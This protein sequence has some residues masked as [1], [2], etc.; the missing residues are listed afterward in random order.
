MTTA[1][2]LALARKKILE[3]S[4]EIV[5][6]ATLLIYGN[7][8]QDDIAKKAF[9]NSSI[10][11]ATVNFTN[12]T[13]TNLPAN[14]GTLYGDA[15]EN[16]YN[17]FPEMSPQDFTRD[18]AQGVTVEGGVLKVYPA[19]T[20]QLE[21]KY[22]PTFTSITAEVDPSIDTYLHEPIVYGIVYRALEDLQEEARAKYYENKYNEMINEKLAVL[23]NYE[24]GNSRG[25]QMFNGISIIDNG[26]PF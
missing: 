2:I 5:D 26:F 6:D 17:I 24:E 14:F 10:L 21:I 8:S 13:S 22:Y 20:A 12:G 18:G 9:P 16:A 4:D 11:S 1:Q 25:G 23:S 19:T 7:L 3:E 15:R